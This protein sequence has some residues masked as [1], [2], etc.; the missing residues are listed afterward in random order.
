MALVT[1]ELKSFSDALAHPFKIIWTTNQNNI[2]VIRVY[3]GTIAGI[4]AT[5]WDTDFTVST[6]GRYYVKFVLGTNGSLGNLNL[7]TAKIVIDSSLP[8]V[9]SIK[10]NGLD[11]SIEILIG[12]IQD[13]AISQVFYSNAAGK[14]VEYYK[15]E[16]QNSQ[17][18]SES[19]DY[20]YRFELANI[21]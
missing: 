4:L 20:Y 8:K 10:K 14:V 19:Y 2:S 7:T 3:P 21:C 9:Q 11:P 1:K 5:N 16:K 6:S 13:G 15:L 17:L 12:V 18:G